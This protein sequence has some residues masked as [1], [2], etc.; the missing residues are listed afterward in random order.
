MYTK[1]DIQHQ[2]FSFDEYLKRFVLPG[3]LH[4]AIELM[5]TT[6]DVFLFSGV[7]RDFFIGEAIQPHDID[8]VLD[9][10]SPRGYVNIRNLL[11]G[12][13]YKINSFGGFKISHK[14]T[15]PIDAWELKNTWT[16]KQS[17]LE[18]SVK[19]LL[20]SVFFNFS[21]IAFHFNT[22]RFIFNDDFLKFWNTRTM[23]IVNPQ[24]PLTELCC[25]NIYHYHQ[26][27]E[28]EIGESVRTWLKENYA[29][30]TNFYP[31]QLHHWHKIIYL[32]NSINIFLQKCIK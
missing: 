9:I 25:L 32:S 3:K 17:N 7:I 31:T 21:A 28:F 19:S 13:S 29:P 15:V 8:I 24:N 23:E 12:T 11:S 2:R 30:N 6:A 18:P 26:K 4:E 20:Q 10:K 16:I 27:Y 1:Y 14:Q 22:R 5:M